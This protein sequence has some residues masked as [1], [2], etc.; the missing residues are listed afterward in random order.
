MQGRERLLIARQSANDRRNIRPV[1][2]WVYDVDQSPLDDTF[3]QTPRYQRI[4]RDPIPA[5][6]Y[7]EMTEESEHTA[8]GTD[9]RRGMTV[10]ISRAEAFRLAQV[11]APWW[12]DEL[13][14][15]RA[16]D[17]FQWRDDIYT[18]EDSMTPDQFWGTTELAVVYMAPATKMRLD[19]TGPAEPVKIQ[20]G[21]PPLPFPPELGR[22]EEEG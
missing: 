12:T 1:W 16:Q 15:P 10:K 8:G 22:G 18:F 21:Q 9:R 7:V 2:F 17:L 5:H 11:L 14:I 6:L 3:L 13:Y 20:D 4:Y 19:S